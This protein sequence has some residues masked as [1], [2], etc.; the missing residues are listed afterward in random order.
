MAE[1][2]EIVFDQGVP[3][4]GGLYLAVKRSTTEFDGSRAIECVWVFDYR[5]TL[6]FM[7]MGDTGGKTLDESPW[8]LGTDW[9][10]RLAVAN[11]EKY[12]D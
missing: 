10:K 3:T 12:K 9:S 4:E 2:L 6:L 7:T 5:G 8:L 11:P 1:K